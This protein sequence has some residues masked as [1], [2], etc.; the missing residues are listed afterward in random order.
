MKSASRVKSVKRAPRL[1]Y[2][3]N[4]N[5]N[6]NNNKRGLTVAPCASADCGVRTI[7]VM[8][9]CICTACKPYKASLYSEQQ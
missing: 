8:F 4:N 1:K 7:T 2:S 9:R 6:N 3:N 5:N